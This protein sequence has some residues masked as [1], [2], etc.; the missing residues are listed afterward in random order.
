MSMTRLR[1]VVI[2]NNT[3]V[4]CRENF[5]F[6][7][8]RATLVP[9][10]V[11]IVGNLVVSKSNSGQRSSL[12]DDN[13]RDISGITFSHSHL[14]NSDGVLSGDGFVTAE[15]TLS[16]M[17][18]AGVEVPKIISTTTYQGDDSAI[19]VIGA[20]PST[21]IATNLN[22]GPSWSGWARPY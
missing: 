9:S 2:A 20:S 17:S 15:Y 22:C 7:V 13:N 21:P 4:N 19:K 8:G 1:I 12:I 14:E 18:V 6:C 11:Q 5:S 16:T 10:N 3:M